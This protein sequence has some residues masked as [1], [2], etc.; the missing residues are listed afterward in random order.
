MAG[1]VGLV[2]GIHPVDERLR[3]PG[4]NRVEQ[5]LGEELLPHR[6]DSGGIGL[7][8]VGVAGAHLQTG[9][10][11]GFDGLEFHVHGLGSLMYEARMVTLMASGSSGERGI[12]KLDWP[13]PPHTC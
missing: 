12:E 13:S 7:L 2:I 1:G 10:G 5:P 11:E 6:T 9:H 3:L 8:L 4:R